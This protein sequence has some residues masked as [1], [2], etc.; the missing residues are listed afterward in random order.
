MG[1]LGRITP[2]QSTKYQAEPLGLKLLQE[3]RAPGRR[4]HAIVRDGQVV[5]SLSSSG[6]HDLSNPEDLLRHRAYFRF[7]VWTVV[8]HYGR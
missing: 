6:F 7:G 2:E 1:N 4:Y 5:Y 3:E 8:G